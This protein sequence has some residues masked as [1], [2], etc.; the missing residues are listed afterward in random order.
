MP[1]ARSFPR[2]SQR[3]LIS[4]ET[5]NVDGLQ[6]MVLRKN[7]R[8]MYLRIKPP[9]GAVEV[10]A[11]ARMPEQTIV[12]FVRDRREWIDDALRKMA[13]ARSR[14]FASV[15]VDPSV[16]SSSIAATEAEVSVAREATGASDAD[17]GFTW[18]EQYV[19]KARRS[20]EQQIPALLEKWTPI[21]GRSPSKIT[22]RA[23]T[24]RWGSCTPKTS[25]IRLNLQLGLMDPKFLEYVLVH[26]LTHL[27]E[28]GHGA[29][30]QARMS[31]ALPEWKELRRELNRCTIF[32]VPQMQR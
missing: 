11:P 28:H 8:N 15:N 22:V 31:D 29:A 14:T 26:E 6:V 3:A 19:E 4:R 7:N 16:P 23:M 2:P 21:I 10:T 9:Y 25:R 20:I 1:R 27:W 24:S 13:A 32:E 18:N 30:F 12:D 17:A 5:L